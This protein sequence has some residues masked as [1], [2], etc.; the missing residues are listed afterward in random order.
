MAKN[1]SNLVKAFLAL[2]MA[3][4]VIGYIVVQSG[5][6]EKNIETKMIDGKSKEVSSYRFNASKIPIYLKSFVA[7]V[8]GS[9]A[10]EQD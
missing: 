8:T 2:S 7:P 3:M 4:L 1:R 6:I 5:A 10:L 9:K